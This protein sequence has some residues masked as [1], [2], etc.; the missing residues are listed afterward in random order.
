MNPTAEITLPMFFARRSARRG[1]GATRTY[2]KLPQC[3]ISA[4]SF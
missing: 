4:R 2:V 1:G 3:A